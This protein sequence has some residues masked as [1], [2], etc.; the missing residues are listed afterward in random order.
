VVSVTPD[1]W[2]AAF[3]TLDLEDEVRPLILTDDAVRMLGLWRIPVR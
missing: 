3:A 1:R 2:R